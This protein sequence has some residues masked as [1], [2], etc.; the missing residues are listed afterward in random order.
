MTALVDKMKNRS[1]GSERLY[2][3][4]QQIRGGDLD[5]NHEMVNA[6]LENTRFELT[7]ILR[8]EDDGGQSFIPL[9][10]TVG[11]IQD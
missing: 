11:Q 9:K 1:S 6:G 4:T 7:N 8:W 10:Q 2:G 3:F 5:N